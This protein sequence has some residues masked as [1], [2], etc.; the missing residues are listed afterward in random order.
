MWWCCEIKHKPLIN[1]D[2]YTKDWAFK[3]VD[4]V[5]WRDRTYHQLT[6]PSKEFFMAT[7]M[8]DRTGIPSF[9]NIRTSWYKRGSPAGEGE[10]EGPDAH[11]RVLKGVPT[12]PINY[13]K[14]CKETFNHSHQRRHYQPQACC[15]GCNHPCI[16]TQGEGPILT[17]VFSRQKC[18][19]DKYCQSAKTS[20]LKNAHTEHEGAITRL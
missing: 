12:S 20:P 14:D 7:R 9:S 6:V 5:N 2:V 1:L 18:K 11:C 19:F 13:S 3:V 8:A 16:A 17:T 4:S 10:M 15:Y